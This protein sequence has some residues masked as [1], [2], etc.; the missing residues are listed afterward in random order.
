MSRSRL[1][2]VEG[3]ITALERGRPVLVH[4]GGDREH[5]VD[6][7]YPAGAV[8]ATAVATLRNEAGGVVFVALPDRVARHFD[9]P[10]LHEAIDH[11]TTEYDHVGYDARPSFSL[12]VNHRDTYTGV[13]DEDRALTIRAL[14]HAA[15][16][17]EAVTFEREFRAPG[18]VHV[19]RGAAD[20][21]H[22][23]QGHTEL[24][25]A[26]AEHAAGVAAIAG[27]EMLDDDSG[28]ALPPTAARRYARTN[29]LAFLEAE[30]IVATL[31]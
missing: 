22:G 12:S 13:T 2:D 29:D 27:C 15:G 9:L 18:H 5:E 3:A 10:F 23:R 19:L 25:L 24:G 1:S 30:E 7:L 11:P 28:R 4:D 16:H 31:A 6:L 8:D 26:L 21:L 17:P 20:G 14:A